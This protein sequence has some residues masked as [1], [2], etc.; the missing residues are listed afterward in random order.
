MILLEF[1]LRGDA[2]VLEVLPHR[3]LIGGIRWQPLFSAGVS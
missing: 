2:T 3:V 1:L